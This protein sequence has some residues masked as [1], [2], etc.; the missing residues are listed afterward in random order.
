MGTILMVALTVLSAVVVGLTVL[1]LLN[2]ISIEQAAE[3]LLDG[4]T[5]LALL[6]AASATRRLRP[7]RHQSDQPPRST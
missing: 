3:E 7:G 1:E 5:D 4:D 6:L 2:V